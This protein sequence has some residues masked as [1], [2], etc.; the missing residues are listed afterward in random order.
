MAPA[1]A[2]DGGDGG[3]GDASPEQPG[4]A[5]PWFGL[6]P[7]TPS[8]GWERLRALVRRNELNQYP[9]ETVNIMRSMASAGIIGLFYGGIPAFISAKKQ[10]IERSDGEIFINRMDAV[11]SVHRAGIRGFIRYGWRWGWRVAAF[12]G[13]FNIVNVGLT[14]YRDKYSLSHYAIAGGCTGALFR[15]HLGLRGLAGGTLFGVLLGL[16][17]GQLLAIVE[18]LSGET[19]EERRKRQ[20]RELYEQKLAEWEKNLSTTKNII[21]ET[22]DGSWE[23]SEE[24]DSGKMQS[25]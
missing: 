1:P 5:P 7:Q 8:S 6:P 14:V 11:Q 22:E 4:L 13:I 19:L 21:N 20:Q 25:F 23:R 2:E 9:E 18:K 24:R 16:P 15:M 12:T 3:H 17:A 10:Y